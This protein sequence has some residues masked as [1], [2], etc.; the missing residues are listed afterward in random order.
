MSGFPAAWTDITR[1][2]E[3]VLGHLESTL[4]RIK[5][6][7]DKTPLLPVTR[8]SLKLW[9]NISREMAYCNSGLVAFQK[10]HQ[11]RL[12]DTNACGFLLSRE[13]ALRCRQAGILCSILMHEIQ[14]CC[15][16]LQQEISAN[17]SSSSKIAS[18]GFRSSSSIPRVD[19]CV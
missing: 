16:K 8:H 17:A 5:I 15:S 1:A 10:L 18:H 14:S 13:E 2:R 7:L 11:A 12:S 6:S 4:E 19:L 3:R 9:D